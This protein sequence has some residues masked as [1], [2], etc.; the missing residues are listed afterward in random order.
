MDNGNIGNTRHRTK[1]N[2]TK[3]DEQNGPHQHTTDAAMS[4]SY[5]YLHQEIDSYDRL[6]TKLCGKK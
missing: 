1:P 2:T 3:K 4:V 5:S 6:T